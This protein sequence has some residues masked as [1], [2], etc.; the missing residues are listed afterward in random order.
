MTS[1]ASA[2]GTWGS[3]LGFVLAAA[4]GAIGLGNIWGFPYMAAQSGGGAFVALY[5]VCVAVVGFPVL[6]AELAIGRSS[7]KSPVGAFKRLAPGTSWP[8]LGAMGVTIGFGIMSFYCVIAGWTVGYL[9]KA[10]RGDFRDGLNAAQSQ[11]MF[12][13]FQADPAWVITVTAIFFLATVLVVRGGIASGIERVSKILMPILLVLLVIIAI[14]S[15]TLPGAGEGIAFLFKA[16]FSKLT[17]SVV[18]N[19]LAQALFS[20]SLGMGAV[21]TYGSYLSRRE[22]LVNAGAAVVGF[23][24]M[25]ALLSGLMIFPALFAAGVE[26][27]GDTGLVFVVLPTIFD[28]LPMGNLFGIAFYFLLTIAALTSAISLLEVIAS[29]W[30][31]ERNWSREKACWVMGA[32]C[33]AISVPS[34]MAGALEG[35]LGFNFMNLMVQIFFV[36]G[37]AF[38]ALLICLFVGWKWGVAPAVDELTEGGGSQ[39]VAVVW[40]VLI[41]YFCPVAAAIVLGVRLYQLFA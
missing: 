41:R 35:V 21:I 6:L 32:L 29:Y 20:L 11:E 23:D 8:A 15:M 25:I 27:A 12:T 1:G 36:Y 24:T 2:R 17:P 37:L 14:R 16:D 39:R 4:G 5:V 33:F 38:G 28:T 34:A 19:A 9:F 13:A 31:D 10:I 3:G 22:N 40:K 7:Q 18:M 30:I 26:P